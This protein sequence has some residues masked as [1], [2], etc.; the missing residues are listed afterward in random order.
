MILQRWRLSM[1]YF[2][3]EEKGDVSIMVLTSKL[4]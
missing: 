2:L 3:F 4:V 1:V